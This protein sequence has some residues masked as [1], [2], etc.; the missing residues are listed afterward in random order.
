MH[1]TA[2]DSTHTEFDDATLPPRA[3]NRNSQ[4]GFSLLRIRNAVVARNIHTIVT[5]FGF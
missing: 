3:V 4:A 1:I 2:D 5:V